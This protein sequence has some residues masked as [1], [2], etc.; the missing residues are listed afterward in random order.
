M[1]QGFQVAAAEGERRGVVEGGGGGGE[2]TGRS[3]GLGGRG[4]GEAGYE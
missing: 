1:N 3:G 4:K 2:K